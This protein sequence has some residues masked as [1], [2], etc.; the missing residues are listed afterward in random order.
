MSNQYAAMPS[1]HFGWS[2]WC[3]LVLVSTVKQPVL[4]ALAAAYPFLTLFAI[5]VT[6]NHW[7]L[8]AAG[9]ALILAVGYLIARWWAARVERR[10][11]SEDR[12][13]PVDDE[14]VPGVVGGS[15]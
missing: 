7:W 3:A 10:L 2:S 1:L 5:V 13:G 12:V 14:R 8:D 6:G 15:G 4:R 9:G 11:A